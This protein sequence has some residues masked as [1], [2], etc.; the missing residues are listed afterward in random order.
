MSNFL[1]VLVFLTAMTLAACG[2]PE[3]SGPLVAAASA[4]DYANSYSGTVTGVTDSTES[5]TLSLLINS[6]GDVSGT[7]VLNA[8][9]YVL[10]GT[11]DSS[12]KLNVSLY[13][14]NQVA[15]IWTGTVVKSTG[16]ITG[17]W[18]YAWSTSSTADGS[19][20]ASKV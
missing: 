7:A 19:F 2:G 3:G 14:N 17:T 13:A 9:S 12:G 11:V 16:K 10:L 4:G 18:R 5:G 6:N 15:H 1:K 20:E 8:N